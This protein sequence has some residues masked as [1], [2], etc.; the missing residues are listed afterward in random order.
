MYFAL[1]YSVQEFVR[2]TGYCYFQIRFIQSTKELN[3]IVWLNPRGAKLWPTCEVGGT[4]I[5]LRVGGTVP[6]EGVRGQFQQ[7][8]VGRPRL[9]RSRGGRHD[10]ETG[11]P[12]WDKRADCAAQTI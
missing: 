12:P 11:M 6:V 4:E 7:H 9:L 8:H 5:Q 1:L 2:V 3:L 10:R